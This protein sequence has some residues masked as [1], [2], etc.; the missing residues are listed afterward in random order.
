MCAT[1][2]SLAQLLT[3]FVLKCLLLF[4]CVPW[5]QHVCL[6]ACLYDVH[7]LFASWVLMRYFS[8][9]PVLRQS[10]FFLD[11]IVW[12]I[13][14]NCFIKKF[15]FMNYASFSFLSQEN[16]LVAQLASNK[17]L[18]TAAFVP[19]CYSSEPSHAGTLKTG[20]LACTGGFFRWLFSYFL[21]L[22]VY[23]AWFLPLY[24]CVYW[25]LLFQTIINF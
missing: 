20:M 5:G 14:Q 16:I 8:M 19:V 2:F 12:V 13:P 22:Y 9:I 18:A 7:I 17:L 15:S 11:L 23:F 6:S 3:R 10:L 24:L 4:P 25:S 1:V 21:F